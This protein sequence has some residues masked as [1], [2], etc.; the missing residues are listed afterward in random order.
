MTQWYI[1]E[2]LQVLSGID[3]LAIVDS[4]LVVLNCYRAIDD[5]LNVWLYIVDPGLKR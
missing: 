5:Q 4:L 1:F 3:E 2:Y